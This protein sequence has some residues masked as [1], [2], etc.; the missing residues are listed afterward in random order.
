MKKL[1]SILLVLLPLLGMAQEYADK[2]HYLVDS[3]ELSTFHKDDIAILNAALET[4][5]QAKE[6]TTKVQALNG[7][8]ENM[9][10]EDWIKYQY[11]QYD[12]IKSLLNKNP[13][14]ATTKMLQPKLAGALNNLGFYGRMKGNLDEALVYHLK[15]LKIQKLLGDEA[16]IATSYNNIGGIHEDKGN[17]D[18]A[19]KFYRKSLKI[20]TKLKDKRGMATIYNN[21]G[22][23]QYHQGDAI[24]S[25]KNHHKSLTLREEMEDQVGMATSYNNI[26]FIQD[27]QGETELALKFYKKSMKINEAIGDREGLAYSYNNIGLIYDGQGDKTTA[28]EYLLKGL[29][30]E[31]ETGDKSMIAY[32][33]NNIGMMYR[34]AKEHAKALEFLQKGLELEEAIQDKK[35]VS[36][37]CANLGNLFFMAWK[38]LN[39]SKTASI[40]EA[41]QLGIRGLK[42]A[43]E[44][45]YPNA[46]RANSGLLAKVY[47][48]EGDGMKALEMY[49]L[50]VQMKDSIKNE[51]TQK[52]AIRQQ[53]QYE[54]EKEQI[55]KENEAKEQARLAAEETSRRNNLQ[56]SLI[57]LGILLLFGIVLSL[58]FIK[59]SANVAEGLIFFAFLILFEF[60]LVFAE[61]YLEQYTN[62]EPMYNLAANAIIALLIFPLHDK[63]EDI[64]KKRIVKN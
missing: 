31:L 54:F 51:E 43:Q 1:L 60:V 55:R 8:C 49:K 26:A 6:D 37:S 5:H 32:S 36:Y 39:M 34:E 18:N 30:I 21:I 17:I 33:Y 19:L 48:D 28:I 56:Y 20:R 3:I 13:S 61:P 62:G 9:M 15:S 27:N 12:L 46:I 41:K 45:G 63:L 40:K 25:L 57:F 59:V 7:I 44:I 29:E 14:S 53:T 10:H 4:Y 50:Y 42:L 47:E 22:A 2:K 58:G 16:G 24:K 35:G 52:A 64:L 38:E 11:L 23:I